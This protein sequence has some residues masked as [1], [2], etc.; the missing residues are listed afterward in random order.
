MKMF[1]FMVGV[2]AMAFSAILFGV[3]EWAETAMAV[4]GFGTSAAGAIS[5]AMLGGAPAPAAASNAVLPF[6]Q[7]TRR[8]ATQV[9]GNMQFSLGGREFVKLPEIGYLSKIILQFDGKYSTSSASTPA[10]FAPWSLFSNIRVDLNSDKHILCDASGYQLFLLNCTRRKSGRPDQQADADF[11][12]YPTGSGN[13]QILR[14]TIEIPI[15]I[16][17]GQN[18]M[19]G[20]INLQAPELQCNLNVQF[21][22]A[23]TDIGNNITA[24][25]GNV[26][27]VYEYYQVPDPSRVQQPY[28]ALHKI[29]SQTET[30]AGTG[31]NIHKVARGGKLLR[32]IHTLEINGARSDAY[33]TQEIRLNNAETVYKIPRW[34][35]KYNNRQMYGYNLPT[36]TIVWDFMNAY[37]IPEESD[38]R[39][40][41]NTEDITTTESRIVVTPGTTFGSN[42]NFLHTLREVYQVPS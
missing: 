13:D 8:K 35:A 24:L 19:N 9:A 23:L 26:N 4:L 15:A 18:F 22:S 17:D 10:K 33:D 29:L 12:S 16:S 30:L 25:S 36:G 37:A 31:E 42:N 41:F 20:L 34:A 1:Y 2:A 5:V 7:N 28:L 38:Q 6:R 11:Y 39:D 40:V 27:V 21:A 32:L 3:P 14:A